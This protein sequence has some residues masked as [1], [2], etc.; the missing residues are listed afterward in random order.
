MHTRSRTPFRPTE[1][2]GACARAPACRLR[3]VGESRADRLGA[4]GLPSARETTRRAC[5]RVP[6]IEWRRRHGGG[7]GRRKRVGDFLVVWRGLLCQ[8]RVVGDCQ[9]ETTS[10]GP[11][12]ARCRQAL[13]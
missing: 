8:A 7:S 9:H 2:R 10:R 3:R 12:K 13:C 4:G 5:G 11:A 1:A 6:E